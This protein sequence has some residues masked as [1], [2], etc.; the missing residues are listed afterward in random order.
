MAYVP[1]CAVDVFISYSHIDNTNGWVKVLKDKLAAAINNR[2]AGH[3][4]V[5]YDHRIAPGVYFQREIQQKL[6]NTPILLAVVSSSYLESAFCMRLELEWFQNTTAGDVI[7]VIKAPLE[8]GQEAP[9]PDSHYQKL[10]DN[11]DGRELTESRLDDAISKVADGITQR[12]R[13]RRDA[14]DKIYVAQIADETVKPGWDAL[15]IR[16][17][18]EG[19]SIVPREI[20]LARF[21]DS[22]FRV[23]LE[24]ARLS[25]H[26]SGT[27]DDSL[28][29]RQ[30]EVARQLGKPTIVLETP[31]RPDTLQALVDRI[32]RELETRPKPSVY[33]IYDPHSD[34]GRVHN[35]RE[36]I[37][38][39]TGCDVLIPEAGEKSHKN[40]LRVSD[41]ILLFRCEAP[42]DWL[43]SQ[44]T[45]LLQGAALRHNRPIAEARYF[46]RRT[47][48]GL[49]EVHREKTERGTWIIERI[50]D[51]DVGD[52][53]PFLDVLRTQAKAPGAS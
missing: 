32:A 43:R 9:V 1:G 10:Y 33:F 36:Q 29:R 37:G 42:D 27:H 18:E 16:L 35:L 26:L 13:D 51:P 21:P 41:G 46:T 52:L 44:E 8:E 4:E 30:L 28:V 23:P 53:D 49:P 38:L 12:L 48:G 11:A 20:L 47:N 24:K 17:H 39:R 19:Y 31:P 34:G 15:K 25:I 7:Q 50:G 22:R 3:A 14:C 5:W 2:L 45:S 40:R 6:S